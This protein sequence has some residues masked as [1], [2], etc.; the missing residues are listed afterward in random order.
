MAGRKP[1]PTALRLL[2]GNA[3]KRP[4][5]KK[6]PKYGK[7]VKLPKWV[8]AGAKEEFKRIVG[9]L[10][11]LE[12]LTAADQAALEAYCVSYAR[13]KTAEA[14]VDAEGQTVME[15]I[16]NKAG[17]IVGHKIKRHPAT[18]IAKDERLSMLKAASLFGFDP[19]SRSR[20]QLPDGEEQ[21]EDDSSDDDIFAGSEPT[22]I[23]QGRTIH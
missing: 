18:I 17:D 22:A 20:I 4:L 11:D 21:P 3:G 5:N 16:V 6:E 10:G 23:D 9:V 7:Q 8:P 12:L 19:S 2:H 1:K 15:P 14:I 13:W